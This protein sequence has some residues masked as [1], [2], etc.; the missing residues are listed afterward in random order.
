MKTKW[1]L[2]AL[3][4]FGLNMVNAQKIWTD[5]DKEVLIR[6]LQNTRETLLKEVSGLNETQWHFK[7]DSATWS[8][9]EVVEHLGVYEE[10]L[11]W[12]LFYGQYTPERSDLIEKVNGNDAEFLAYATDPS[13]GQS[14]WIAVPLG[15]FESPEKLSA[16]FNRFRDEVIHYLE[17]TNCDLRRHFTYRAPGGGIWTERDLH[18]HTLIWIA[19]TTRHTH[20]IQKIKSDPD[21]PE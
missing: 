20:Q 3:F 10:Y 17:T 21:F 19:H 5:Q 12:D 18:Q 1:L 11:Y 13:K 9:A 14:P 8:V 4:I 16:F 6:G 2:F 7:R 15:R